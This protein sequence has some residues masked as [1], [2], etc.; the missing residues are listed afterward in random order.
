MRTVA[1][2][3]FGLLRQASHSHQDRAALARV[4]LGRGKSVSGSLTK[5]Y[6]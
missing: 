5:T 1:N 6:Q 3:Y 2:S 4:I